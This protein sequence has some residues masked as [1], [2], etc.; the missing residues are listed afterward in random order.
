MLWH[1][2]G[3]DLWDELLRAALGEPMSPP[4]HGPNPG[5]VART[6]LPAAE[7]LV[8]KASALPGVLEARGP[9][10]GGT[11]NLEVYF[12]SPDEAGAESTRRQLRGIAGLKD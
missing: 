11:A 1:A 7:G 5:I 6:Q 4:S 8:R 2:R 9:D 10:H 12:E 3:V